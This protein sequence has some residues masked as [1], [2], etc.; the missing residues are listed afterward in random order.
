MD[1]TQKRQVSEEQRIFV[2]AVRWDEGTP[3]ELLGTGS[4]QAQL[5][6]SDIDLFSAVKNV[7]VDAN[8]P[9]EIYLLMSIMRSW[10][11]CQLE[12]HVWQNGRDHESLLGVFNCCTGE[13][14]WTFK[15]CRMP[16]SF[17]S[18]PSNLESMPSNLESM[19]S[20]FLELLISALS[21]LCIKGCSSIALRST[22]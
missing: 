6:P 3:I 11:N 2:N 9:A 19:L 5:Y 7:D 4:Q 15:A 10:L 12:H 16:A 18:S 22:E 20:N 17:A 13:A 8:D 1:I 14:V 21:T